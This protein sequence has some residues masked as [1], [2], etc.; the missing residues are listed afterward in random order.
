VNIRSAWGCVIACLGFLGTFAYGQDYNV[1]DLGYLPS[2]NSN[3]NPSGST[4]LGINNADQATG[5]SGIGVGRNNFETHSFYWNGSSITDLDSPSSN[6]SLFANAIN[7]G[8]TIAG[9]TESGRAFT[10]TSSGG[11][12]VLGLPSGLV[13]GTPPVDAA[14]F[15]I[16]AFGD[17]VG[18]ATDESGVEIETAVWEINGSSQILTPATSF[19][20]SRAFA[21]N[22]SRTIAGQSLGNTTAPTIW[23][24][25]SGTDSWTPQSIG[26]L[27]GTSGEAFAI[28]NAG[29]VVGQSARTPGQ[30]IGAFIWDSVHGMQDLDP[31]DSLGNTQANG[32]NSS[33]EVVGNIGSHGAF[34]WDTSDG[35]INLQTLIDPNSPFTL[36]GAAGINDNGDIIAT[37]TDSADGL[38]HAVILE[39]VPEPASALAL[40]V[41]AGLLLSRSR[42]KMRA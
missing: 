2:S 31:T 17:V 33:D 21:I 8:G 9:T 35:I 36:T 16:N 42:R 29:K 1:I 6:T 26:S 30:G 22:S 13:N 4:G 32:I 39:V 41:G 7:S 34:F 24:Y 18:N 40:F 25:N 5:T 23:I 3:L 20:T 27:G 37:A 28:N 11:L 14:A 10:Y 19:L 15:G 38:S 12:T